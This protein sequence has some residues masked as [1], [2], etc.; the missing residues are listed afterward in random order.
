MPKSGSPTFKMK[1]R[2]NRVLLFVLVLS[3]LF[4]ILR[5]GN[6]SIV[7]GEYYQEKASAQQLRDITVNANRGTIYDA[8]MKIIAQ[9]ATVWTVFLSPNDISTDEMREMVAGELSQLLDMEKSD[10]LEKTKKK[11]YYEVVK[12]KIEKP[13][14]D[15]I[16]TVVNN[17]NLVGVHLVEDTKRYYPYGNFLST[18]LGF[19]GTDNQGLYGLEAYYDKYLSGTAGRIVSAKNA[20][21]NDLPFGYEKFYEPK[22][23]NSLVL[24]VDETIQY[25]VEKALEETVITHD[26]KNRAAAIAMDVNTGAILGMAT[27]PDFNLNDPFTITDQ[28][29]LKTLDGLEGDELKQKRSEANERQWK[30]KAITE[31]YEPGSVFKVVTGSAA[32]EEGV[33]NVDKHYNCPGYIMVAGIRMNC[34]ERGGHGN[35][36]F[37][38]SVV[39]SC[40]PAFVE[41]GTALGV[42][43]FTKY[44]R[45][46]GLTEKTGIDLPGEVSSIYINQDNMGPVELASSSFGQSNKITPLQMIT[47]AAATVNGGNLIQPYVVSKVLD[48]NNNVVKSFTPKVRRQVISTETSAIMRDALEKA[49]QKPGNNGYVSGY[50]IG[51]KSGTAEKLDGEKDARISSFLGFAPADKPQIIILVMVDDPGAGQTYGNQVAAP[52]VASIMSD[53]LPYIG[54]NAQF[55]QEELEKMSVIVPN[56]VGESTDVAKNKIL[57]QGLKVRIIGNGDKIVKQ[58]PNSGM[59]ASK[60][61]TILLYTQEGTQE[62][63]V[64]M[65]N[66]IGISVSEAKKRASDLGLN[67]QLSTNIPDSDKATVV[68]QS[69]SAGSQIQKGTIISVE[70]INSEYIG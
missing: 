61:S 64:T 20:K 59:S 32:I 19:T 6:I 31:I 8:N 43:R 41:M 33:T 22:N 55:T 40:N 10:I 28:N 15:E 11:N 49:V 24:T 27:K 2:L 3:F 54:I 62:E 46:F 38:D 37:T 16:R 17:K 7:N 66:L 14:A 23:G 56:V 68:S 57:N 63:N 5:V 45:E 44:F 21:G 58:S 50:R 70:V 26:V 51:G 69:I 42:D 65:P 4:L 52:T 60:E 18:V 29:L 47:A 48:E 25:F 53:V 39:V 13:L 1:N 36:S 35:V 9:S 34:W 30:N 67:L 12:K